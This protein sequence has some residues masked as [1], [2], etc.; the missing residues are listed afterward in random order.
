MPKGA[1]KRVQL[2]L[3]KEQLDRLR[4]IR[5]VSNAATDAAVIRKALLIQDVLLT[6]GEQGWKGVM[7]KQGHKISLPEPDVSKR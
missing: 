1:K 4:E 5:R 3:S 6:F 7:V 2:D